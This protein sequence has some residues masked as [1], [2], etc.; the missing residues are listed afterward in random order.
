[1]YSTTTYDCLIVTTI[2]YYKRV[3][4]KLFIQKPRQERVK[5]SWFKVLVVDPF[6]EQLVN[7][8]E[9]IQG[10][11]EFGISFA[12]DLFLQENPYCPIFETFRVVVALSEIL[13]LELEN[14]L[15]CH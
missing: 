12:I 10:L 1:M 8:S 15:Q 7:V 3:A 5:L 11:F 2:Y 14:V 9:V 13:G 6:S 4:Y